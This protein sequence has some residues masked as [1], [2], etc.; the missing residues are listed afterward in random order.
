MAPSTY[1]D[2]DTWRRLQQ[3]LPAAYRLTDETAPAEEFW[4]WRGHQVHLDRYR[5][6]DAPLRVILHHGVGTNGRQM[7]LIVGAP[8]A[9]QGYDVVALDNLGY[10]LTR[11]APGSNPTY[12]DWIDLTTDFLAVEQ[13]RDPRPTVMYG[14]SAGGMVAYHTAAR[15]PRGSLAG[16]IGMCFLDQRDPR[17]R[18]ETAINPLVGAVGAP[19]NRLAARTPLGRLRVPMRWV[20][21]MSALANDPEAMRVFRTD[22]TSAANSVTVSFLDSYMS[23]VPAVEPEEFTACPILLTQPAEDHWTPLHLS[24]PFLRRVTKVPVTTALLDNAGHYPL[25]QP[26]LDQMH[27]AITRFLTSL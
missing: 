26:G 23:Y 12:D 7:S 14:L 13:A 3:R 2:Q 10:G 5:N 4:N 16:I 25:E 6:P 21:K 24:E 27:T 17:V 8:L 18:K 11:V 19:V 15:A 22:R 9:R 1:R 20:S